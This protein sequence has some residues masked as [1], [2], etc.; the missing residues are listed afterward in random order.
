MLRW[1]VDAR[2]TNTPGHKLRVV[3]PSFRCCNTRLASQ[4]AVWMRQDLSEVCLYWRYQQQKKLHLSPYKPRTLLCTAS[5]AYPSRYLPHHSHQ[6]LGT[7]SALWGW[8]RYPFYAG[9]SLFGLGSAALYYYQKYPM[10]SP[11]ISIPMLTTPSAKSFTP[12]TFPQELAQTSL[13]PP[14]TALKTT[15][16]SQSQHLMV[17]L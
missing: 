2:P 14:S 12:A 3:S 1:M 15:K 13:G 5:K 8:V 9:S 16:N 4:A 17:K 7:M 11:K 10:P 6:T